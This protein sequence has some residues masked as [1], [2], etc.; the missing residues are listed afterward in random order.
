MV[1]TCKEIVAMVTSNMVATAADM[2]INMTIAVVEDMVTHETIIVV[3]IT[4]NDTVAT[5]AEADMIRVT[6]M[7]TDAVIHG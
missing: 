4:K 1:P 2:V 7:S 5:M 3:R 6:T